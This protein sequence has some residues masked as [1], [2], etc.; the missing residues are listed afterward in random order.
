MNKYLII[1][2]FTLISC[3]KEVK[4]TP[5]DLE[6]K[7]VV[8]SIMY[9]NQFLNVSV[10]KT[11]NILELE[12]QKIDN[13]LVELWLDTEL[14]E[15]LTMDSIGF[16]ST[17]NFKTIENINYTLRVKV[18]EFEEIKATDYIPKKI[19]FY[20]NRFEPSNYPE[21]YG[22]K[23]YILDFTVNFE[24][25]KDAF[26]EFFSPYEFFFDEQDGSA[27]SGKKYE[28]LSNF[29][30]SNVFILNSY[31]TSWNFI[32]S[33][34]QQLKDSINFDIILYKEEEYVVDTT[35]KQLIVLKSLSENLYNYQKSLIIFYQNSM[36]EGINYSTPLYSNIENGI[37]IFA[38]CNLNI[39]T[40]IW[41]GVI[42]NH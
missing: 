40:L 2:L 4:F 24:K 3:T 36:E 29:L 19:S 33:N 27:F 42:Y 14:L 17:K 13:A 32:F 38:G 35:Y 7:I 37:G 12:P 20:I 10:S 22:K 5:R 30:T 11:A 18:P 28:N 21:E 16:Y 9:P 1:V 39:D 15:T 6:P 8:N 34:K 41:N 25:N 26:F 23:K 31:N